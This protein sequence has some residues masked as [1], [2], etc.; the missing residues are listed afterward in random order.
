VTVWGNLQYS[1]IAGGT[2]IAN[3]TL[4]LAGLNKV[5]SGVPASSPALTAKTEDT[6]VGT[7]DVAVAESNFLTDPERAQKLTEEI[8]GKPL[9]VLENTYAKRRSQVEELLR[10]ADPNKRLV[11]NLDDM[12]IVRNPASFEAFQN[13]AL[14]GSADATATTAFPMPVTVQANANYS[15]D[16]NLTMGA[17][18]TLTVSGRLDAGTFTIGGS[19]GRFTLST[20][21]T[22]A[23][24]TTAATGWRR[25]S[26]RPDQHVQRRLDHRVQRAWEPDPPRGQPPRSRHDAH[27]GQRDEVADREQ[28]VHREL[29]RPAQQ[30]RGVRG[31]GHDV[32]RRR[33]PAELH[34]RADRECHRPR[35]LSLD[36]LGFALVRDRRDG[37]EHPGRGR[38]GVRR[39]LDELHGLHLAG[40]LEH[41]RDEQP[42]V[43]EPH[44]R[45]HC[46]HGERRRHAAAE[47]D[48][49]HER[50][51]HGQRLHR[52]SHRHDTG[53][54]V[55]R[56]GG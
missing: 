36:R 43:P 34:H 53:G 7:F 23:T 5:I 20:L 49:D 37:L 56:H 22:L 38:H 19:A 12:T 3:L 2:S 39:P 28:V 50:H 30:R 52:P 25:P 8:D 17:T 4:N 9:I 54:G 45:W 33:V 10:T 40:G 13:A 42:D 18:R 24:A 41:D 44:V 29:R 51:G 16:G 31:T 21:G 6:P 55:R 32:C 48:G 1:G 27:R 11:I 47:R 35:Q 15:L 26:S 14:G 46:R